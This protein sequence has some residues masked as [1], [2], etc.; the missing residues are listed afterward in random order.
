MQTFRHYVTY[1]AL[2]ASVL[3]MT[4]AAGAQGGSGKGG[5]KPPDGGEDTGP[6]NNLSVP[7]LF[8]EGRGLGGA[9]I[10]TG[11]APTL[12]GTGLRPTAADAM[13]S[14]ED[15]FD[16]SSVY[17][18]D[19]TTYFPQQT[20]SHWRASWAVGST[21]APEP[22]IVNWSDNLINQ[23]WTTKAV[24]RVETVLYQD[25]LTGLKAFPMNLLY[26]SGTTEMQGTTGAATYTGT[27][28]TVYSVCPRLTIQKITGQGGSPVG[29]PYFNGAVYEAFGADGTGYYSAEINVGG[30]VIYGYNWMIG[31]MPG[32]PESKL[33]WWRLTFSLDPACT[34]DG[35][36][37]TP[38]L[39]FA[40]R[41]PLD[42]NATYFVP[43]LPNGHTS[44]L[45]IQIV[46][47]RKGG[48]KPTSPGGGE[49]Q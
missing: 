31:Q 19:G 12:D 24:I 17:L 38:N 41:D 47:S 21:T 39:T 34:V 33:G 35:T 27:Y 32:T 26:G 45:D 25:T 1:G 46:D 5:G 36:V 14:V 18:L 37:V 15:Y 22:V 11:V 23:K 28:R 40:G 48:R 13:N 29:A 9:V 20:P 4:A 44:F 8:A 30:S 43:Q 49:K 2:F 10:T 3:L 42:V 16:T 7:V 6:G